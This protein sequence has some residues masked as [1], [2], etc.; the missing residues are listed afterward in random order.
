M[1]LPSPQVGELEAG[2][3]A[4]LPWLCYIPGVAQLCEAL[5]R[6][7]KKENYAERPKLFCARCI[8]NFFAKATLDLMLSV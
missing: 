4:G 3:V 8:V 2:V 7:E 6:S 5:D 1:A